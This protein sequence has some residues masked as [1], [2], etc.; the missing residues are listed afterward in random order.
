MNQIEIRDRMLQI[1]REFHSGQTR[2]DGVTPYI[3]H[4]EDVAK[5]VLKRF[6]REDVN[7][8]AQTI[9]FA[10]DLLED[11]T[12][13]VEYLQNNGIPEHIISKVLKL[14]RKKDQSYEEFIDQIRDSSY[15]VVAVKIADILS[16]LSDSPT[17]K[18][19]KKYSR[20]LSKLLDYEV[21]Q[22]Q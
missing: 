16:N 22:T 3:L 6:A 10:H 8:E 14:T 18:Q 2:R 9:A 13:T 12:C 17:E 11:T 5:R 20:A 15:V 7:L 19:V 21:S 1:A 4:V